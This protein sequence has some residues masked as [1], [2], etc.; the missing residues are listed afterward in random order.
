M[1]QHSVRSREEAEADARRRVAELSH[2]N[3]DNLDPV[4][5]ETVVRDEV[6]LNRVKRDFDRIIG[7]NRHLARSEA[8]TEFQQRYNARYE[9]ELADR[10]SVH[11]PEPVMIHDEERLAASRQAWQEEMA[12]S[13]TEADAKRERIEQIVDGRRMGAANPEAPGAHAQLQAE[14]PETNLTGDTRARIEQIVDGRKMG[15]PNPLASPVPRVEAPA[16]PAEI[17][18]PRAEA[19]TPPASRSV[20]RRLRGVIGRLTVGR[21]R[22]KQ[23]GEK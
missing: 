19:Q 21:G 10:R 17:S 12:D 3:F 11:G 23:G 20:S 7:D 18:T 13:R 2:A 6:T 16:A 1:R 5:Q 9:Q 4:D 8:P 14:G 22:R 15:K